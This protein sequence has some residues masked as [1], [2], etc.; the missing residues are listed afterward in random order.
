MWVSSHFR[1]TRPDKKRAKR[2]LNRIRDYESIGYHITEFLRIGFTHDDYDQLKILLNKNELKRMTEVSHKLCHYQ[3][4]DDKYRN[5]C[6][7]MFGHD[8]QHRW[9]QDGSMVMSLAKEIVEE[10]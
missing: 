3:D 8:S 9:S 2:T 1:E 5:E 7:L 10:K 4:P 6:H